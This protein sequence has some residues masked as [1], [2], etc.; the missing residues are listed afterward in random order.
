MTHLNHESS[1]D[2]L[3]KSRINFEIEK[4]KQ[5]KSSY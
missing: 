4:I 2:S 3:T 1:S 5:L